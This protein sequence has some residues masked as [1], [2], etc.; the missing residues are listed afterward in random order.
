MTQKGTLY[1]IGVGPG[2]A[3]LMTIKAVRIIKEVDIIFIPVKDRENCHAYNIATQVVPEL[4]S[5]EI[6][7]MGFPMT[8]Q[9]YVL[10]A[11]YN[12]ASDTIIKY[13]DNGK[14]VAFLTIGDPTI[15][16]TYIYVH[17]KV[18]AKGYEAEI[19]SGVTSFCASAARLGIALG[20]KNEEIHI[21]PSSYDI[22]ITR[23]Y[24]GTCVYMKSGRKLQELK[25]MLLECKDRQV[26]V[27]SNCGMDN[28]RISEGAESINTS[29]DYLTTVITI[30]RR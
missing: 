25:N 29:L 2:D 22:D 5:K 21:I 20:E 28:E 4:L 19:V 26:Y 18:I 14:S 10:D 15:Y 8:K 6:V 16:S 1:G 3:E 11:T 13:L 27:I 7:C 12:D 17:Q 9:K 23:D 24:Q 30:R